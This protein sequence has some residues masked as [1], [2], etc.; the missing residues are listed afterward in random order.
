M[1]FLIGKEDKGEKIKKGKLKTM[2][3]C[4]NFG[5]TSF[6]HLRNRK[7]G[8]I[9]HEKFYHNCELIFHQKQTS[10]MKNVPPTSTES[11]AVVSSHLQ[12]SLAPFQLTCRLSSDQKSVFTPENLLPNPWA[13]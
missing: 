8:Y 5:F 9:S 3:E 6:F 12:C 10:F 1:V 7:K 4:K 13:V 11:C 2:L